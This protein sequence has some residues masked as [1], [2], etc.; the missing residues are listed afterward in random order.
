ML[1]VTLKPHSSL[2]SLYVALILHA[3]ISPACV[4]R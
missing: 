1:S 4:V 2:T 3:E